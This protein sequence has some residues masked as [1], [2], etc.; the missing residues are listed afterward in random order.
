MIMKS[1]KPTLGI[2]AL[3]LGLGL[4]ATA[5]QADVACGKPMTE[6]Q[7]TQRLLDIQEISNV[8]SLHEY[9]HNALMHG[10]DLANIWAKAPDITWTN[11]TDKYIGQASMKKF[12]IDGLPKDKK[13]ALWYHMLTTPVIEV[14]GDGKTAKA[15]YMS[16]GN[17]S[18]AMF[19]QPPGAQWTQEKY[20]MD[21][22]KENGHWKIWHL[23]TYVDFYTATDKSWLNP[24]DNLA[25]PHVQAK[26]GAG[27]KEEPGVSFE[28][29][30]PDQK[31]EYYEGYHLDRT[32]KLEPVLPQPYCTFKDTFAY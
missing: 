28:M 8:A 32:P 31:G 10:E 12:Y 25:A 22:I 26:D 1:I 16:F 24:K 2:I 11:N 3:S 27:V 29:A 6:A 15:I 7:K 23:R 30:K 21:F 4:A 5:A 19:N 9:Y 13:G 17:V 18:G 20:G 14:A